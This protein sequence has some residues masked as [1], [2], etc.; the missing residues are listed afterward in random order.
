MGFAF[1][2]I[3]HFVTLYEIL[4]NEL[5]QHS[6]AGNMKINRNALPPEETLSLVPKFP[7]LMFA[8][9]LSQLGLGKYI[10]TLF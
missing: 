6:K 2:A 9:E 8:A 3:L 4:S 7:I 1:S 10:F 5:W